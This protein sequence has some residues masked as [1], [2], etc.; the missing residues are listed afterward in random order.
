MKEYQALFIVDSSKEDSLK[1]VTDSINGAIIK[2]KGNIVKEENWGKQRLSYPI[3]K[4][5]EAIYYKLIFSVDP[6]KISILNTSY[7]LNGDIM[8]TMI[9]AK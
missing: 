8:R 6:S 4:R 9:T 2:G 3:Q 1:E 7:K 5:Q